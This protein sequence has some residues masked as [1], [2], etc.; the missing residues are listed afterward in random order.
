MVSFAA[1]PLP[2]IT[3]VSP[4]LLD[5]KGAPDGVDKEIFGVTAKVA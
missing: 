1:K 2:L 5:V 3:P 4:T